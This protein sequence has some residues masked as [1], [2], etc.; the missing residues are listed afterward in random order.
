M[1]ATYPSTHPQHPTYLSS[2]QYQSLYQQSVQDPEKFWGEMATT[3][4]TWSHPWEKVLQGDMRQGNIEWFVGGKLNAC[5]NCVDRHLAQHATQTALIW[6]GDA[7]KETQSISYQTLYEE[8]CRFANILKTY[9]VKKGDR[10]CLYMPMLPET[11]YAML[12]CARI[13]AVHTVV[14]SGFSATALQSRINDAQCKVLITADT[15]VRGGKPIPLKQQADQALTDCPSIQHV[16]VVSRT[17]SNIEWVAGRDVAYADARAQAATD[18]PIEIMDAND[19]LFILYTSGST[20]QPKGV[21][22]TTGG[23][24]TYA[25]TTF[26]YVFN[27]HAGDVYWCTADV[28]WVTGHSYVVYGPLA[29]AAINLIYEGVPTYPDSSRLWQIVDQHQVN[30]FYTAPTLIRM[31]MRE[32]NAPLENTKRDS[33][34]LLGSV[35]EPI[36]PAA[37]EWYYQQV[38]K[39][40]CPIVD[41]WWQTETGGIMITPLPGCGALKPG[42]AMRPFFGVVPALVDEQG[43]EITGA[44]KGNLVIKQAWPGMLHTIYKNPERFVNTY[45]SPCPGS[46]FTED[47]ATRD[48]DGDYWIGGRIDD[49][50]NV[51]GHRMGTAEIESALV[52][53]PAVAEAAVVGMPHPIKGQGVYAF[54]TPVIGVTPSK[55][56][57]AELNQHLREVIGPIAKLDVL[58]WASDLPKTRSGKIMRRIL[59][60]IAND[61][62]ESG[63]GDT[64][65]L[66]NAE[67]LE[68]LIAEHTQL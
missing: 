26:K 4:L 22:H 39:A 32:G 18:C 56:L 59:R 66:A 34:K 3:Q 63:F 68:R 15:S 64:S 44:G 35:G 12:A 16:I 40:Q 23:Y 21:V 14:F 46:Y 33:L 37:W 19:P 20:G 47:C 50:L 51:S 13:G 27:Y 41:T 49:V 52:S 38:G 67:V 5:F 65:T 17:A 28:G 45:L 53:H 10:V 29:N 61:E 11:I 25:A 8:V 62:T 1:S 24:L 9:G 43:K 36:N 60:K 48:V 42:A 31:L 2:E 57:E 58:Q 30:I 7:P 54:I 6:Q 55:Q